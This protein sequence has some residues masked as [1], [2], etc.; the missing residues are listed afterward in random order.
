MVQRFDVDVER[1]CDLAGLGRCTLRHRLHRHGPRVEFGADDLGAGLGVADQV[2]EALGLVVDQAL[3]RA[4]VVGGDHADLAH[5]V[6]L[7]LQRLQDRAGPHLDVVGQPLD[8]G[9]LGL[10]PARGLFCKLQGTLADRAELVGL[11]PEGPRHGFDLGADLRRRMLEPG[12]MPGDQVGLQLQAAPAGEIGHD[13]PGGQRYQRHRRPD[14]GKLVGLEQEQ[15]GEPDVAVDIGRPGD[16]PDQRESE[17]GGGEPEGA[18][19]PS[20]RTGRGRRPVGAVPCALSARSGGEPR[21]AVGVVSDPDVRAVCI[22]C[23]DT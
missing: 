3:H 7:A 22:L 6:G 23:C 1:G 4:H 13:Q 11:K 5:L 14:A 12:Q 16:Q 19:Q 2:A 9:L 18:V 17:T 20:D 21:I 8:R 10:E 15:V